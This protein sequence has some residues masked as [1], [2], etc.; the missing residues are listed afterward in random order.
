MKYKIGDRI[1]VRKDLK[2]YERYYSEDKKYYETM[3]PGM[4]HLCGEVVTIK[5]VYPK[6]GVYTIAEYG[7]NW[8]D[9]MFEDIHNEK[10]VITTDGTTTTAKL[11]N[12]KEVIKSAEAKCS[13]QDKFD[14]KHG[15]GIAISRLLDW[16]Y[17]HD[18]N[19][20]PK[21]K[22]KELLKN[23][24][25]GRHD[26]YGWFIVVEDKLQYFD[27][28]FS[29]IKNFNDDLECP[30]SIVGGYVEFLIEAVSLNAAKECLKKNMNIVWKR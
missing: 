24:L 25:F 1:R 4:L 2:K 3:T 20:E 14:F 7:W 12:G 23:G 15:V 21:V 16:I 28:G 19:E 30:I 5:N 13:P 6:V 9:E 29:H 17:V 8:T 10:I 22:P 11:Y 27:G 18:E 26:K